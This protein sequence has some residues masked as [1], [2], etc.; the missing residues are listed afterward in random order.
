YTAD[1]IASMRIGDE[2]QEGMNAFLEKRKPK[3]TE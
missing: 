3:W 2:G 1:M